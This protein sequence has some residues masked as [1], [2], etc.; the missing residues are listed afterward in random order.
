MRPGNIRFVLRSFA[1]S[2]GAS[3][4]TACASQPLLATPPQVAACAPLQMSK[5]ELMALRENKFEIEDEA[6]RAEFALGLVD[7]FADIDPDLRDG[8]G[9]EGLSALLRSEALSDETVIELAKATLISL[10]RGS[11]CGWGAPSFC[12]D[13]PV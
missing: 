7:C 4:L 3:L 2:V 1:L 13:W 10:K 8:V 9:Y 12:R 5:V 11:G 6:R